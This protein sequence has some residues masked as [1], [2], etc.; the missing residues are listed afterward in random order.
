MSERLWTSIGALNALDD[1][2]LRAGE[3]LLEP[4]Q[5]FSRVPW[6]KLVRRLA[7]VGLGFAAALAGRFCRDRILDDESARFLH[8]GWLEEFAWHVLRDNGA[9]DV[10]LA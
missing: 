5:A 2:A 9:F 1:R 3:T 6:G 10:R 4:R 7:P 8:G